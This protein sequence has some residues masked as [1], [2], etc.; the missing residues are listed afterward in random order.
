[1][2]FKFSAEDEAFRPELGAG[3]K[4]LPRAN[5][6]GRRRLHPKE[7]RATGSAASRGTRMHAADGSG[8]AGRRNTA[9]AARRS[10]SSSFTTRR[11]PAPTPRA[12]QR[13]RHHAGRPDADALGHRGAEEALRAEDSLGRGNLVPGIF[14][15][16]LRLRRRLAADPRGRGRRLLRRQRSEGLDLRRASRRLVHPAGPHRSRA[17]PSTRASATCW[18][19]CTAPASRF[20]RWCR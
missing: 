15:A 10:P 3:S 12:R 14:R 13:P 6:R 17:R 11:W 8:S 9:G 1:M 18:S 4:N 20:A 16:R 19:T 7:A 2:D 5:A